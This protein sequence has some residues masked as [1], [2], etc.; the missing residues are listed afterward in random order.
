MLNRQQM[1]AHLALLGWLP[2]TDGTY[3]HL[4]NAVA[5]RCFYRSISGSGHVAALSARLGTPDR[6]SDGWE[7]IPDAVFY[8][9]YGAMEARGVI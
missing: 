2:M 4:V 7:D 5:D 9:I 6:F 1:E 8:E 3:Y